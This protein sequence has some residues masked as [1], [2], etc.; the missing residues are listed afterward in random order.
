MKPLKLVISAFGPYA[1]QTQIDFS[2]FGESGL[3]LVAGDTGAGKTTLFDAISFALYGEASGGKER[4]KSKSFRSD[5]ASPRT[6]TFVEF[7]FSHRGEVWVVKRNPEYVRPKITGEG[8]TTQTAGAQ[9]HCEETGQFAIGLS[10]VNAKVYELLGLTQDQFTQTVMI[11][12]GDFLKILNATS[13]ERKSLFQKLFNTSLYESV[14]KKL[15]EMSSDCRKDRELLDQRIRVAADM[16]KSDESFAQRE[17][18]QLYCSDPKYADLLTDCLLKLI[19]VEKEAR[20]THNQTKLAAEALS[21]RLTEE[22]AQ[23]RVINSD[24]Q[25]LE[26][27]QYEMD[28]L[29]EMR[30]E[31][32]DAQAHLNSARKAQLI[33]P[34]EMMLR[35]N[36]ADL[37]EHQ[38]ALSNARK[39]LQEAAA[40]LPEADRQLQEAMAHS[41]DAD[42]CLASANQLESCLPH[43]KKLAADQAALKKQQSE[44]ERLL[45]AGRMAD[46]AYAK[47]REGYYRSQAGLLAAD[48][49]EGFPCPVC[50]SVS[51][52]APAP[53]TADAV[54]REALEEAEARRRKAEEQVQKASEKLATTR[55]AIEVTLAT[56]KGLSI[57][58]DE[59]QDALN[60]RI[61]QLKDQAAA[62]RLAIETS[63]TRL[64]QLKSRAEREQQKLE[65]EMDLVEA[66]IADN[67]KLS[68][69]YQGK[70][71]ENGFENE[72]DYLL[73]K[74]LP[75]RMEELE[76]RLNGYNEKRHALSDRVAQLKQKLSGKEKVDLIGLEQQWDQANKEKT[77]ADAA[78]R[79]AEK[80]LAVHE[81]AFKQIRE[82][83]SQIKRK[84]EHWAIV[85]ELYDCC[86][87]K[88]GVNRRAKMTFEAYVQQY[89][90]KQVVSAANKRLTVLTD[91]MFVLRC[92][93]EARDRVRQSG[94]DLDVLDRS[95]GQWRD[96][97]TLSGGESFLAS[98]ALAL[99]LS[100][101]VQGQ[102]GAIRMDAMFIDEGFGTL[103][104]NALRNSLKVLSDLADGKRLIGIISHVHELEER[105]EKQIVVTKEPRGSKTELIY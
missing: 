64:Q 102:S 71:A 49:R 68:A 67:Q 38:A 8:F 1:G 16:I 47:A 75:G 92:K 80:R 54:T 94:L 43:L 77:V 82:A 45:S 70:L 66:L 103:D 74:M 81:D 104:E 32:D 60:R 55:S 51:H 4:R 58:D 7:T 23:G 83:R 93:E 76:K 29:A 25:Q 62:Y 26:K 73:A 84:E 3:F 13:D 105:I 10:D 95:T 31:M 41:A 42:V 52:P 101:V 91:G 14:Q 30:G 63:R 12:Q 18:L 6:E 27:A 15:Q 34:D 21:T 53:L 48:L 22:I 5:Y 44:I 100:D 96:V 46:S 28:R 65:H 88:A 19:Q 24:W 56:L 11:A 35:R 40:Q 36:E 2:R 50:G 33:L 69:A 99:G 20:D 72:Q 79:T 89:Y 90:F 59:T 98:L 85:Q 17:S 87:G 97:T 61:C 86:A 37:Q 57:A 9:M 39:L 78:M